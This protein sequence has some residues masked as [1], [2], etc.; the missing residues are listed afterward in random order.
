[1][2]NDPQIEVSTTHI[3]HSSCVGAYAEVGWIRMYSSSVMY[4]HW[5]VVERSSVS[6]TN[7]DDAIVDLA[8]VDSYSNPAMNTFKCNGRAE[9]G[10]CCTGSSCQN[11]GD[12]WNNSGLPLNATNNYWRAA[13]VSQCLCNEALQ[14]C[15][16]SGSAYGQTTPPDGIDVLRAP[17]QG[18]NT[19][20]VDTTGYA[21]VSDPT[22]PG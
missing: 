11:G 16:C 1:L 15:I 13:P 21:V 8:G 22:C 20:T 5:G 12:V 14:S 9:P 17:F 19:G 7:P 4:S 10:K 3:E 18:S 2:A 6:S